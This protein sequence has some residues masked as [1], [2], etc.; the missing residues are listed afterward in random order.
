MQSKTWVRQ[1]GWNNGIR[2]S[3]AQKEIDARRAARKK[4]YAKKRIGNSKWGDYC[5]Y[6]GIY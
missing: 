3:K 1:E 5:R 2:N 6:R 4:K